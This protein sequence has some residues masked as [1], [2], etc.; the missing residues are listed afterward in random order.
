MKELTEQEAFNKAAAYCAG[1]EHCNA[2]IRKKMEAWGVAAELQEEIITRLNQEKYIDEQRFCRSFAHDKL[3]YNQ[4]G[5][6]KIAQALRQK[7]I[8]TQL[9][10]ETLSEIDEEEYV[11]ILKKTLQAKSKS[12][13]AASDYERNGK[14]IRFAISHGFEMSYITRHLRIDEEDYR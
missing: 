8:S 4:W 3:R 13:K 12:V 10:R 9:I 7:E 1:A 6:I 2:E 5:R 11:Q 14:L